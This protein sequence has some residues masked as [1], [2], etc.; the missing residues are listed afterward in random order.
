MHLNQYTGEI[1]RIKR[2]PETLLAGKIM[3]SLYPLHV[4]FAGGLSLKILYVAIGL[5]PFGLLIT[6]FIF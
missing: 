6:R 2:S 4:G 3:N 5:T 1:L